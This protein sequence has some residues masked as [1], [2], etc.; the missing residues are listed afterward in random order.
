MPM[1]RL[2]R[3]YAEGRQ[4]QW[5]AFC[6]DFDLAVQGRS[7]EEVKG[8]IL[9]QLHLYMETVADLPEA[10]RERML[11]RRVPLWFDLRVLWKLLRARWSNGNRKQRYEFDVPLDGTAQAA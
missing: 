5:E 2:I 11:N 8:K 10:E 1:K 6:L 4:G 7:L 3:C 9:D